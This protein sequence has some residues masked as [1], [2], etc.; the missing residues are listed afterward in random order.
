MGQREAAVR[1]RVTELR[2]QGAEL[3]EQLEVAEERPVQLEGYDRGSPELLL[4]LSSW[5]AEY[6]VTLDL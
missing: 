4:W 2:A 3:T 1:E 5:L 6:E